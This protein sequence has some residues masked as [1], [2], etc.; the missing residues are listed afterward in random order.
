MLLLKSRLVAE[1][2]VGHNIGLK[3]Y[4]TECV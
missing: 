3:R 2:G 1:L 4:A